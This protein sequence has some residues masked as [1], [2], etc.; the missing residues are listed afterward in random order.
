MNNKQTVLALYNLYG[1][2]MGEIY[3]IIQMDNNIT[4]EI[5]DSENVYMR[6]VNVYSGRMPVAFISLNKYR[7]QQLKKLLK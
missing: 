3:H 1:C 5:Y 6:E 4:W 2:K 7:D